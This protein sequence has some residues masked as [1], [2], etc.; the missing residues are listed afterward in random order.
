MHEDEESGT[1]PIVNL[2]S[3]EGEELMIRRI[4]LRA[5]KEEDSSQRRSLFRTTCKSKGKV[6]Q[7]VNDSG[8]QDNL[9][10]REMVDKLSLESYLMNQLIEFLGS[11][12]IKLWW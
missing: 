6:C 5:S 7:V 8:S 11:M 4:V 1:S 3:E 2:T 12:I 9:V 10:S